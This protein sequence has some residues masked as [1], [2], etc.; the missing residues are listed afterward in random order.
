MVLEHLFPEDW[1][2]HK[3][4]Y[5][6]LL[7]IIYSFI[8]LVIASILFP[9]DPALVAVAF[10]SM[11]LLPELYKIFSIE[12]R[13]ES[14]GKNVS[15]KAMWIA[16]IDIVKVYIYLFL[17]ILLVY[18]MGT[19]VLA[20]VQNND[21]FRE[22][23]EIRF[24]EGFS[25]NAIAG[26]A[27]SEGGESSIFSMGLFLDLLSNNFL[28]LLACFILALLSGDGA[29]F[30]I[31]WNASV[32]GTIFGITAKLAGAFSGQSVFAMFGIIML[33]VFPHMII[34]GLAYF[35]AAISGSIIS[36]DVIL[37]EFSSDRFWSVFVFNLYLLLFGIA[38]LVLGAGVE[39]FVLQ[40]V[41]VYRT[42]IEMSM[43]AVA[44]A[45]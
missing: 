23:L 15:M 44:F 39:A 43:K 7:G 3:A 16:D 37:E 20:N 35:L 4:G 10:T 26:Q 12:E 14:T 19:L 38:F 45:G 28:V 11:L 36:K 41:D 40:H 25:G 34:E 5:A 1:L 29:I 42:I 17:G 13:K 6:F 24:G 21:L 31:T 2:E 27:V 18:S 8:G 9:G 22:Q 32:W 33:I 30:L